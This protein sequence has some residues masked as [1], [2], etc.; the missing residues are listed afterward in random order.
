MTKLLRTLTCCA[1]ALLAV[2][3]AGQSIPAKASK[4]E[5]LTTRSTAGQPGGRLVVALRSEPKTL[6]PAIAV[7]RPSRLVL[8]TLNADLI[9]INRETQE[10]EPALAK[11]WKHSPDGRQFTLFL[12]KGIL[13]SDGHPFDADDVLFS[14][15]VYLDE[16]VHSSQRDLLI[17]GGQP[18]Q[19]HKVDSYTVRFDLSQPYAA[20]ERL[21]DSIAM[22]PK[23]KLEKPYLEG[24]F[25]QV[26]TLNEPPEHFAGLGPFHVDSY[27]PGER[28]VLKKNDYYWKQDGKSNRLPY[29]SELVFLPLSNEDAEVM[30]SQ[31]GDTDVITGLSAQN[32]ALLS[33]GS[34]QRSYDLK[35]LGPGLEYN[36]LLL[37]QNSDTSGRLPQIAGKEVWFRNVKFRQAVSLAIDRESIVRLVY[38]GRATPLWS[39]VTPGNKRWA[40]NHLAQLPQSR[41]SAKT[42]LRGEGFSWDKD[43]NLV[44]PGG[45]TVEFSIIASSSNNQRQQIAELIRQDLEKLGMKVSVAALDFRTFVQRVTQSHDYEAAVMGLASGD[46]DPNGEMNVWLSSG[47]THLWNLTEEKPATPW[48][49]EIDSLMQRQLITLDPKKR[50]ELYDRVQEIIAEEVPI[51][52][53][54]S[55]HVLVG[56]KRSLGNFRPAILE[57]VALHNVEELYWTHP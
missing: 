51:I 4:E 48:E 19:V 8:S 21:F 33:Q 37:N 23:H 44:D 12:R 24:K 29:L 45:Q 14:F 15:Q 26:W 39:N 42:L 36:F 10:T 3:L 31:A 54:A 52:C 16:K 30:R 57:P 38:Q 43:G 1:I 53:V 40:D 28:I 41:E 11:S 32:F 5:A 18:I 7:D 25:A 13:F 55:P 17:V 9:H 47:P 46:V 6:N 34:S 35:D 22:L 50:K 49:S 56:A 2:P 20:A 27:V